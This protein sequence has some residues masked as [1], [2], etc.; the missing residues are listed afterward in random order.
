MFWSSAGISLSAAISVRFVATLAFLPSQEFVRIVPDRSTEWSTSS[1]HENEKN[2]NLVG[3]IIGSVIGVLILIVSVIVVSIFLKRRA[4]QQSERGYDG[5]FKI[6]HSMNQSESCE[7]TLTDIS[8]T[9]DPYT[10]TE[11]L[12]TEQFMTEYPT[13]IN[14]ESGSVVNQSLLPV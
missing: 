9:E 4:M 2:F 6:D 11:S 5:E 13:T 1:I 3:I 10:I 7:N 14:S 12:I 8:M